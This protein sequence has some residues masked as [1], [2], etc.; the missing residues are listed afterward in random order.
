MRR[1]LLAGA[2]IGLTFALTRANTAHAAELRVMCSNGLRAVLD[3]LRPGYERSSGDS[4]TVSYGAAA[5]LKQRIDGGAAFDVAVLTPPL[6][7]DLVRQGRIAAD[8][9]KTIARAGLGI[10]V[11]RGAPRPDIGTVDAFRRTMLAANSIIYSAAGA[12]GVA[13]LQTI[14]R[15]GIGAEVR[16]RAR[17]NDS[18]ANGEIVARGEA[19]IAV[20]LIP[21]LLAVAGVD[22]VGPFPAEIQSFVVLAAGVASPTAQR[23]R[24][25]ALVTFLTSA[26]ALAVIR[27]KGMEPG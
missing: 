4:L 8:S 22:V 21:E 1:R 23:D 18:G 7:A 20:Q 16:A 27:A 9:T 24:A 2:S 6:I 3:E 11:R 17:A 10:A 12:S 25:Q 5:V 15:L 26:E 19:E 13:F 14:D